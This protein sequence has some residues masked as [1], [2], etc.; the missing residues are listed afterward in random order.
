MALLN[1]AFKQRV[2]ELVND[3]VFARPIQNKD[4]SQK[5]TIT[6]VTKIK[7]SYAKK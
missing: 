4:F 3:P 5:G 1:E 7:P 6:L 2:K